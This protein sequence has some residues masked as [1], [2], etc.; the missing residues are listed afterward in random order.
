L[1]VVVVAPRYVSPDND[2]PAQGVLAAA[3]VR[4]LAPF[5]AN[6]VY[7]TPDALKARCK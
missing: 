6:H 7:N 4:M 5:V 2:H 1:D 3:A